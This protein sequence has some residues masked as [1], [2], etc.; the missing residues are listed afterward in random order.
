V[1]QV[2]FIIRTSISVKNRVAVMRWCHIL[3][4]TY[5][6]KNKKNS[7]NSRTSLYVNRY[8]MKLCATLSGKRD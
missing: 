4:F 2:G 5:V 7:D 1:D 8:Q 6:I 3:A